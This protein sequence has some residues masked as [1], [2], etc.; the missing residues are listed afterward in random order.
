MERRTMGGRR[1]WKKAKG[2]T[3]RCAHTGLGFFVKEQRRAD[4]LRGEERERERKEEEEAAQPSESEHTQGSVDEGAA[5][6]VGLRRGGSAGG[7]GGGRTE[8]QN[9]QGLL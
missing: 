6:R 8:R 1:G 5:G 2:G 9:W 7:R 3:P 4:E